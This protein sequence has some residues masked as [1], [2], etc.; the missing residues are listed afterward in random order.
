MWERA[1]AVEGAMSEMVGLC[2]G[3]IPEVFETEEQAGG[4]AK[5]EEG[6]DWKPTG[7]DAVLA[8]SIREKGLKKDLPVI[9]AFERLT[10][11]GT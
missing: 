7:G 2:R 3:C 10:L 1:R 11:L 4:A 6:E 9:G 5:G 8:D